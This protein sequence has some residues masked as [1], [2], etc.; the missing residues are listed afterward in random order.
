MSSKEAKPPSSEAAKHL[1]HP[2][3]PSPLP[4][5]LLPT[6][7]H[8]PQPILVTFPQAHSPRCPHPYCLLETGLHSSFALCVYLLLEEER[9]DQ[10]RAKG[11]SLPLQAPGLA[12]LMYP[13]ASLP[14]SSGLSSLTCEVARFQFLAC[15]SDHCGE[16]DTALLLVP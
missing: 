3:R 9:E 11:L 5:A 4:R 16:T 15:E 8:R 2:R 14:S 7:S 13:G 12:C 6:S 1:L 10:E